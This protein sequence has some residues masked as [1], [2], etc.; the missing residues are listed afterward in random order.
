MPDHVVPSATFMIV[1]VTSPDHKQGSLIT[2]F[3]IWNTM[4]GASLLTLPWAFSEVSKY[5]LIMF[6]VF[7]C[8]F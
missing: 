6:V 7:T 3:S 1:P 8:G 2:I 5:K 4:V